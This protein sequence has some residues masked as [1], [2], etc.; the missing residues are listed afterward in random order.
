M[1]RTI[2]LLKSRH[3]VGAFCFLIKVG[4]NAQ[5]HKVTFIV[6]RWDVAV[7]VGG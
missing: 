6:A 4:C 3:L 7:V 5:L 1:N 2:A